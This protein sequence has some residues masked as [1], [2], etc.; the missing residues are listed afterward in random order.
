MQ[1]APAAGAQPSQ[2]SS[3]KRFTQ[4]RA[5]CRETLAIRAASAADM[6]SKQIRW[7]SVRFACSLS[8]PG[9]TRDMR[10][11]LFRLAAVEQPLGDSEP[12]SVSTMSWDSTRRDVASA[13]V[14]NPGGRSCLNSAPACRPCLDLWP[15]SHPLAT[16][17]PLSPTSL[18]KQDFAPVWQTALPSIFTRT[19]SEL[20]SQSALIERT[21]R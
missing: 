6:P 21:S 18:K 4:R 8:L 1:R 5:D 3:R 12:L 20:F 10:E 15:P 14:R 16:S 19:S 9:V 13:C 2:P 17:R 7:I 11:R